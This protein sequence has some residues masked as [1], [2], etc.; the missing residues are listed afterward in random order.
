MKVN[1]LII[2]RLSIDKIEASEL[3]FSKHVQSVYNHI[4]ILMK[5]YHVL[6]GMIFHVKKVL[7]SVGYTNQLIVVKPM[8]MLIILLPVL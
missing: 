6:V 8:M 2:L 4:M 1:D 3:S 5:V 7:A